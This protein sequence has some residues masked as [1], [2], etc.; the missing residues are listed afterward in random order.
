MD[1]FDNAV[2]TAREAFDIAYKK[3][4]ELVNSQKQKFDIA[5]IEN[6]RDKDFEALGKLYFEFVKDE[7]IKNAEI[8]NLVEEIK[9]KNDKIKKLKEEINSAKN[10]V[11]CENCSALN[12]E[13]AAFCS[14]CGNKLD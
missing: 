1:F 7:N 2:N 14:A 4:G 3:T 11:V 8:K 10:K 13:T 12:D 5:S 9:D 6:K